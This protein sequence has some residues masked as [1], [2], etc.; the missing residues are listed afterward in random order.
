M[1]KRDPRNIA[2]LS[3]RSGI[4]YSTVRARLERHGDAGR[5]VAEPRLS[6]AQAGKLGAK[7]SPW[8]YPAGDVSQARFV[9]RNNPVEEGRQYP[10]RSLPSR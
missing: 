1:I 2:E 5:A 8:R 4:P 10:Q 6:P 3:R 7:R 9:L